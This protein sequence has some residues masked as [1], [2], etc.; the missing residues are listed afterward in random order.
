MT[1]TTSIY[2]FLSPLPTDTEAALIL[3]LSC[4][5]W[6]NSPDVFLGMRYHLALGPVTLFS[7]RENR[8]VEHGVY[9][10]A[11]QRDL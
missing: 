6:S 9:P 3:R 8:H 5:L 1:F 10:R 2:A 4:V 11:S 7:Y